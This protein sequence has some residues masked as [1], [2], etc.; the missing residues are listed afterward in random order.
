MNNYISAFLFFVF[1]GIHAPLT[2]QTLAKKIEKAFIKLEDDPDIRNGIISLTVMD[3]NSGVVLFAKNEHIGLATASTLKTITTATAYSVL[4]SDFTYSTDLSYTG[5]IDDN[6]TLRGDIT[7]K[8]SGDPTL[9]SDRFP[10]SNANTLLQRWVS[11]I[12]AK[13]IKKIEGRVIGDDLLFNGHQA[14]GG[15]TWVDMGNYYGAGVSSLNWRENTFSIVLSA[16][17]KVGDPVK[18]IRTEPEVSYL[19]ILNEVETGEA[20]SGDQV[21]AYSA[22]YS[23]VIHLRGKYGID[24]N[25]K[26]SLSLPNGAYDVAVNLQNCLLDEGIL[27]EEPASTAFL[28]S[29]LGIQIPSQTQLLDRYESPTLSQIAHWFNRV[30]INLYGEALLKTIA[31]QVNKNPTTAEMVKWEEKFWEEKLGILPGEL[32]IRDGSGLSPETR[33][34][35]LAMTKILN[36]AKTQPWFEDFHENLPVYN[37][38]KMKS[39]TISGVLGYTGY[40]TS[41]D[42]RPLVFSL[43]INNYRGSAPSMRQK[44]FKALNSLK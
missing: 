37:D 3:A 32:R 31:L 25:K 2:A 19:T 6:G 8:G 41:S 20:G 12:K 1:L 10:Q 5:K 13:G 42:G 4:G 34:T 18:L 28:N 30:S 21:Y 39:G 9:G 16:G 11:A 7:L 26:I 22:P 44:M 23:S 43:L 38:M 15:W 40:Q 29:H 36:Y 17:S 35:T 33:V 14:P 27:V 24:L